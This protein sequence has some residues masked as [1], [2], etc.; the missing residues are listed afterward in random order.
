MKK[1][2]T[3]IA[4]FITPAACVFIFLYLYPILRTTIMSFFQIEAVSDPVSSWKFV[5]ISNYL[6]LINTSIFQRSM[7]NMLKVWIFGGI[8]VLSLALLFAVILTN[9]VK[10]KAFWRALIYLPNIISAVAYANMWIYFVFNKRFGLLHNFF[11]FLGLDN[12]A[13][14]DYM[15]GPWKLWPLFIPF[16]SGSV[17][18]LMLIFLGGIERIP[19]DYYEA[20]TIDGASKFRQFKSITMP[21]MKSVVKTNISFWTIAVVGFFV[22]SQM[23]SPVTTESSTIFP[24]NYMYNVTFGTTG[25]TQRDAGWGAAV[26][27][28]MAI[29]VL[30]VFMFITWLLREDDL[31][32]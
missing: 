17:G 12:L 23:W 6:S 21:L 30:A 22:W 29:I 5:G 19:S 1:S 14:I 10:F 18:Y 7:M 13:K 8:V 2:K 9:G 3:M 25:N 4:V 16:C 28:S 15:N 24:M 26:G 20:A 27:I 11:A 31:E 32:F